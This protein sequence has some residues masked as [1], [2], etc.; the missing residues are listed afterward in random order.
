MG[1]L[2]DPG[3]KPSAEEYRHGKHWRGSVI[4][5]FFPPAAK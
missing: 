2:L 3:Y 4:G 1:D 5:A